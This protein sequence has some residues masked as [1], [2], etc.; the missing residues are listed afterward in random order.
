MC[1]KRDCNH[2]HSSLSTMSKAQSM[3]DYA[4]TNNKYYFRRAERR[5]V[6][7][8]KNSKK[9]RTALVGDLYKKSLINT[10]NTIGAVT[11]QR[12]MRTGTQVGMGIGGFVNSG[13]TL[14][15]MARRRRSQRGNGWGA[16]LGAVS[17]LVVKK[18]IQR[19]PNILASA[20]AKGAEH[21]AS[22]AGRSARRKRRRNNRRWRRRNV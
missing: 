22:R 13:N 19:A 15:R 8:L 12:K 9:K 4:G 14:T 17:K 1:I 18:A 21:L 10:G 16:I 5:N 3:F 20:A 2:S 11:K 6:S 7:A